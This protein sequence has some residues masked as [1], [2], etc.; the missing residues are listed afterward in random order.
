M[1]AAQSS[2]E[3]RLEVRAFDL[4]GNRSLVTGTTVRPSTGP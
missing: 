1:A 2:D 4:A 3:V